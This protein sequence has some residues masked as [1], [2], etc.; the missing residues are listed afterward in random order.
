MT[1]PRTEPQALWSASNLFELLIV[2]TCRHAAPAGRPRS[3]KSAS[4]LAKSKAVAGDR[5]TRTSTQFAAYNK[6]TASKQVVLYPD[7]GHEN[8]PDF[9]DKTYAFMMAMS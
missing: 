1:V 6:I 2:P 8:L 5:L 7:F 3:T 4:R 9:Q